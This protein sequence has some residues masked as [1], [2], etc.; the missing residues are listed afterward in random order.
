MNDN[1]PPMCALGREALAALVAADHII[2][3]LLA[4]RDRDIT[5]VPEDCPIVGWICETRDLMNAAEVVQGPSWVDEVLAEV[6]R[7]RAKRPN[8]DHLVTAFGEEV[9]EVQRAALHQIYEAGTPEAVR[10]ELIQTIAVAVRLL[11][12]GD[13]A[14]QLP[15][16]MERAR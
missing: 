4:E 1:R 8:P 15:A 3:G 6:E 14:H 2:A 9:G 12:E 11:E 13:P 16:T 5:D 10:L 7:A